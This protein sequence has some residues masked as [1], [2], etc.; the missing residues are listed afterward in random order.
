MSETSS[1]DGGGIGNDV[2]F[3]AGGFDEY[4]GTTLSDFLENLRKVLFSAV[5]SEVSS[6]IPISILEALRKAWDEVDPLFDQV[7]ADLQSGE[8]NAALWDAGLGEDSWQWKAKNTTYRTA[9]NR[10]KP[11]TK[12]RIRKWLQ[13]ILK[14]ANTI[15]GSLAVVLPI[16]HAIQEYKDTVEAG[17]ELGE[18]M[19]E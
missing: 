4:D 3:S 13:P 15:L 11:K 17:Y 18:A 12:R 8:Y 16:A 2:T 9:R 19:Y 6:F 7:I 10:P 1:T 14:I 5:D